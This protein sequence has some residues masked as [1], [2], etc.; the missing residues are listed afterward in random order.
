MVRSAAQSHATS[1][2]RR[3]GRATIG[4][5]EVDTSIG[6][7]PRRPAFTASERSCRAWI[8]TK[9]CSLSSMRWG[10][11]I[12]GRP[13]RPTCPRSE[14]ADRDRYRDTKAS[15]PSEQRIWR[16]LSLLERQTLQPHRN[17]QW[18][19]V[20]R[21]RLS[22]RGCSSRLECFLVSGACHAPFLVSQ[23]CAAWAVDGHAGQWCRS[24][25]GRKAA[26]WAD[27]IMR[28][29]RW[30]FGGIP[31]PD[32]NISGAFSVSSTDFCV[33]SAQSL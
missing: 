28:K 5:H 25:W 24:S 14:I 3:G 2:S 1:I 32:R 7:D 8:T 26:M 31:L 9:I 13:L 29:D 11:R 21:L 19:A 18:R 4:Q 12:I 10:S 17:S 22:L 20:R 15:D 16:L 23:T 33:C 6:W 30:K 27:G